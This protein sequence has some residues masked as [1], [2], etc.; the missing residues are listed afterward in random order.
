MLG[1]KSKLMPKLFLRRFQR[2]K[3]RKTLAGVIRKFDKNVKILDLGCAKNG[4][5]DYEEGQDVTMADI[6]LV[7]E[8]SKRIWK[9]EP[10]EKG[11]NAE[12]LP[13][14]DKS[15]DVI[16]FNAV[17]EHVLLPHRALSEIS[18]VIKTGGTLI[19]SSVNLVSIMRRISGCPKS[20]HNAFSKESFI[21]ILENFEFKILKSEMRGF[22]FIPVEYQYGIYVECMKNG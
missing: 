22:W 8:D 12:Y 15:F 6:G 18:R 16:V 4:S 20:E 9:E 19:I 7:E 14:E 10:N 5:W 13:Y 2:V 21:K 3:N 1:I 11:I 17:L